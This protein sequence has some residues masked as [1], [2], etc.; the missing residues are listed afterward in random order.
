MRPMW[1]GDIVDSEVQRCYVEYT[2]WSNLSSACVVL[3]ALLYAV[4]VLLTF[5]SGVWPSAYVSFSAGGVQVVV[6]AIAKMQAQFTQ[7]RDSASDA[8]DKFY[9]ARGLTP[10]GLGRGLHISSDNVLRTTTDPHTS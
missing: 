4:G 7:Q 3:A 6:L 9:A 2:Y 10:P 8:I 1:A 5:A